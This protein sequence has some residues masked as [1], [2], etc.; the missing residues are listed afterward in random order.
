MTELCDCHIHMALDGVWW[1]NAVARHT[2]SA[3]EAWTR[4]TLARYQALGVRYLRDGGDKWGAGELAARLAP[5]YGLTY[6]TPCA[7]IYRL[8]HYGSFIGWGYETH[9][10][11]RTLLRRVRERGG[12]FIK[13]MISGLMDFSSPGVLTEQSLPA[14]EI[15]ALA[16]LAHEAG[17]SVM[18]HA[19]GDGAVRAA[20]AA[21][22]ESVEHGA[23]LSDETLA[24]LAECRTVWVPTLSTVGNLLGEGRFPDEAVRP[25]LEGQLRAVR[26]AAELG[27]YLA[28]GSDAGAYAVPHGKGA[29]DEYR[30]LSL[31]LGART[32]AV[33]ARGL[34]K[35]REKF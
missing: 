4:A 27:A 29:L 8:G 1:K 34:A 10:D 30:W 9:A 11:F 2:P 35:I 20:L 3:D 7:P 28:P 14:E 17:F 19:N 6:R 15:R 32:E 26:R 12:H 31:A 22:I 24:Q 13:L 5:E 18:A 21:G 16:D 33:L 25:I 23:Y